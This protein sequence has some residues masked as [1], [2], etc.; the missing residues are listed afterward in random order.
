MDVPDVRQWFTSYLADFAALGRGDLDDTARLLGRYGVPLLV[1]TDA[2]STAFV[3][4]AQVLAFCRRQALDL[5]AVGYH[6]SEQ[7]A[8]D[9]VV[10]NRSCAMH[11]ARLARLR[12]DG[13][14]IARLEATYL[15]T[16]G[17]AGR[18]ISAIVVHSAP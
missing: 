13:T 8:A 3:D 14:E 12:A 5:R 9:T 1:S 10:L 16:E 17:P 11:R 7:L 18:R 2:S 15:I 4:E 6:R